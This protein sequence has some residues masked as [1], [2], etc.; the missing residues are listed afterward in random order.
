MSFD[1]QEE[2]QEGNSD[3]DFRRDWSKKKNNKERQR[4]DKRERREWKK[5][6]DY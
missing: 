5:Q 3:K 4:Y 2:P 1:L 6:I